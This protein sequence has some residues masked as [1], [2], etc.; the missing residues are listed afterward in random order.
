MLSILL[1]EKIANW[2]LGM[3]SAGNDP[4]ILLSPI[5]NNIS[6]FSDSIGSN[7]SI[8]LS[9]KY[10]SSK[11]TNSDN[12]LMSVNLF[13]HKFIEI[14]LDLFYILARKSMFLTL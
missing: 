9:C 13:Y 12:S 11:L 10:N 14:I 2:R 1:L 5:P 4:A 6:L 3:L 7:V 8:K